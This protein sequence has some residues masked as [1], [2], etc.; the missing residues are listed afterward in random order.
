MVGTLAVEVGHG[1]AQAVPP[2]GAG[3]GR[4]A[5]RARIDILARSRQVSTLMRNA[6]Q[7]L[8][9]LAVMASPVVGSSSDDP[10]RNVI[11]PPAPKGPRPTSHVLFFD[12]FS[13]PKLGQWTAD[14]AGAWSVRAK[15]LKAELPDLKQQHS[16]LYAGSEDW[17]NYAVDLDV[18]GMRGVDK[19]VVVRVE[20]ETGIGVDLRGPGYQ[21]IVLNRREWPLGRARVP[22]ANGVWQHLRIE[23]R[24]HRYKV[25]VNG[26]PVL[27]RVDPRRARPK[28]RI[29]LA[30]YTGGVGQCTV[31]YDNVVVT[32]LE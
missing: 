21:D 20:N 11:P 2:Y 6:I 13:D 30:A 10:A 3:R 16:F 15:M 17:T 19:G 29:G 25:W 4:A 27:D 32:E 12:D 31:Y 26:A 7:R 5:A 24:D 8:A 18:C 22:N 9:L 1:N 28:G 14:E 23:A